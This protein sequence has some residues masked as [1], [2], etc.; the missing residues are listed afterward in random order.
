M[1]S[2]DVL[3]WAKRV[4]AQRMQAVILSNITEFQRLNTVK[5]VKQKAAQ[6]VTH[7]ATPH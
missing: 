3:I 6:R 4:E 7:R 2:E 1:T 5:V